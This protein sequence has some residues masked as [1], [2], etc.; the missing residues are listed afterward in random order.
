MLAIIF[1]EGG[2]RQYA[3]EENVLFFPVR[4]RFHPNMQAND[5]IL[6]AEVHQ[7]CYFVCDPKKR[8]TFIF[9]IPVLD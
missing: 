1:F 2:S 3:T 9:E 7:V 5:I 8:V 4:A 6:F